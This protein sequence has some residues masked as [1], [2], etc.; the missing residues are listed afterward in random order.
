MVHQRNRRSF[1]SV[2]SSVPLMHRDQSDIGSMILFL[3]HPKEMHPMY[4]ALWY[5]G[6]FFGMFLNS[7]LYALTGFVIQYGLPMF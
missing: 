7:A 5:V 1:P 6:P 4:K 3:D 2:D